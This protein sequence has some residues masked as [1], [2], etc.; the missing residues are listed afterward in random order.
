[1]KGRDSLK[2]E[3]AARLETLG[4]TVHLR[5]GD[6]VVEGHAEG[7]DDLGNLLLRLPDGSTFAASAGE[8]TLQ[9]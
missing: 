1:M 6:A 3:W 7:V 8:V 2:D 4:K 9:V 5:W